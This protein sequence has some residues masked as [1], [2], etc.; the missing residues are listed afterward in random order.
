MTK[1][2]VLRI[3]LYKTVPSEVPHLLIRLMSHLNMRTYVILNT[4]ELGSVDF[5]LVFQDSADTLRYSLD[6]SKFL[7][8]FEGDT[9]SFLEGKTQYDHAEILSILSGPEWTSPD[10]NP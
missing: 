9:P 7:L 6:G 5:N 10:A 8:K 4:S 2:A 3:F 1:V